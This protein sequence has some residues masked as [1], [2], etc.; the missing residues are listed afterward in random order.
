MRAGLAFLAKAY[1][2]RFVLGFLTGVATMRLLRKSRNGLPRS[3]IVAAAVSTVVAP[4]WTVPVSTG[5]RYVTLSTASKYH[6]DIT[7][8]G[9]LGNPYHWARLVEPAHERAMWAWE[10]MLVPSERPHMAA[11]NVL[12]TDG[13]LN[14]VLTNRAS[15]VRSSAVMP[16]A[17]SAA[18][19]AIV[20]AAAGVAG[21]GGRAPL[22]HCRRWQVPE[23]A[24]TTGVYVS[25]PLFLIV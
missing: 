18:T 19:A 8:P 10:E 17:T 22:V 11:L 21:F 23:L 6:R 9:S 14:R 16:G 12:P 13:R 2:L 24:L 3:A 15:A 1:A 7:A 25:G 20:V 5:A 4:L